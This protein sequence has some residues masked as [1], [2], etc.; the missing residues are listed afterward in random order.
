MK[1]LLG[2]ALGILL[3]VT[4]MVSLV[5]GMA[6]FA[7]TD[8]GGDAEVDVTDE[9]AG[10]EEAA[11]VIELIKSLPD[12]DEVTI[13]D[14]DLICDAVD[15]FYDLEEASQVTVMR[16]FPEIE[17]WDAF[18]AEYLN[19]LWDILEDTYDEYL[20]ALDE[21]P[22]VDKLTLDDESKVKAARDIFDK[23]PED[24][25]EELMYEDEE[26]YNILVAAEKKIAEL[27]KVADDAAK[28]AEVE[29]LIKA[30]PDPDDVELE[31]MYQIY[32]AIDAFYDLEELTSEVGEEYVNKLFEDR[33]IVELLDLEDSIAL[34]EL[35]LDNYSDLLSEDLISAL[36]TALEA[37]NEVLDAEEP[38]VDDIIDANIDLIDAI[39]DANYVVWK[40]FTI[41]E[42]ADAVYIVDSESGLTFRIRQEG[43]KDWAYE[44][45]LDAGAVILID[46]E[47]LPEGAANT[48]KGSLIIEVLPDF[49]KT[50]SVGEH[51]LTVKF[52]NDVT[53]DLVFTVRSAAEVPASGESVSPAVYVGIAMV[54]LAG[55]GFV[56]NKK[57]GKKES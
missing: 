35:L 15:G 27:K 1:R 6:V 41:I 48:S 40:N 7:A 21:I 4:M 32:E 24:I 19:P 30:L 56:V 47:E 57:L 9:K 22:D 29:D 8:E 36:E 17:D 28:V 23:F 37:A 45:F 18:F 31:D 25:Q 43:I 38:D 13:D 49:L 20:D 26:N 39:W 54:L 5:P 34:A 12:V 51:K 11:A 53:M 50:L 14:Y 55:A 3:S 52:D 44:L 16:A 42:G 33:Y 46:G 10:D 2:K